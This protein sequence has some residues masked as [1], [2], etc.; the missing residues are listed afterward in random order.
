P[1]NVTIDSTRGVGFDIAPNVT[2][3]VGPAFALFDADTSANVA[4]GLYTINLTTGA[5]AAV[6][7][8]GD[9]TGNFIGLAVGPESRFALG[10]GAGIDSRVE[11]YDSFS[12]A[13]LQT[14]NPY[15]GFGGGVTTAIGD[16]NRDGV[17][18]LITGASTGGGPHVKVY[19]GVTWNEIYSFFAYDGA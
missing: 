6:G 2:P 7:L 15:P 5:A 10:S 9:G 12:G 19:D 1:L 4:T 18:D 16:V 11:V 13:R 14:L 17:P 3:A 8:V